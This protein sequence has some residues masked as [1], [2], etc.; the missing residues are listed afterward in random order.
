MSFVSTLNTIRSENL[1]RISSTIEL[2]TGDYVKKHC[3]YRKLLKNVSRQDQAVL[4]ILIVIIILL[5][6]NAYE[7]MFVCCHH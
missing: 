2:F 6:N 7:C 4:M 3:T 1:V 5:T